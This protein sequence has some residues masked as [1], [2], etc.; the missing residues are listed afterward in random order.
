MNN[1]VLG[2]LAFLRIHV[3]GL[4]TGVCHLQAPLNPN[5]LICKTWRIKPITWLV[6]KIKWVIFVKDVK[7]ILT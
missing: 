7:A 4:Y 6:V 2:H 5:V 3:N 1:L